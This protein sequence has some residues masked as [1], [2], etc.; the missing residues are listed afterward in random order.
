MSGFPGMRMELTQSFRFG[1]A[2]A[3]L[4]DHAAEPSTLAKAE[5]LDAVLCRGNADALAEVLRFLDHGAHRT[6]Q[7]VASSAIN[8]WRM[9]S[10]DTEE[11]TV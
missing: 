2:I 8:S 7:G 4:T 11:R 3:Q 1:P 10:R 5:V 9:P 6:F